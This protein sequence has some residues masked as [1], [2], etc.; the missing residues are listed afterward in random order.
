MACTIGSGRTEP[1]K[2]VVG[3]LKNV[4]IINFEASNYSVTENSTDT[5]ANMSVPRIAEVGSASNVQAY[6]FQLKGNSSYTENLQA[7]RENGT[8]AFEQVLELQLKKLTKESHK[9]IKALSFGRPHIIVE[10]YNG[11]LFLAGRE[12]GMEVT[13]GTIATGTAMTDMSGYT[14]T[15]TAMERKPAQLLDD[16][17]SN[18]NVVVDS[19]DSDTDLNP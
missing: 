13:G 17:L 9:E 1:C 12:H 19:S 11:N 14:L 3:G 15:F 5:A 8:L 18:C 6:R 4:Y 16:T 7:S 2:D 10:D